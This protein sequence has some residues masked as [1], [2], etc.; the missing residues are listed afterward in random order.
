MVERGPE[1]ERNPRRVGSLEVIAGCMFSGKTDEVNMRLERERIALEIK[2]ERGEARKDIAQEKIRVFKP[3]IDNRYSNDSLDSHRGTSFPAILIEKET[4]EAIYEHITVNTDVVAIDE[5][6]FFEEN[7]IQICDKLADRGIRVIVAGLDRNF[8]GE[9][10]GSMGELLSQAEDSVKLKA[11]CMKCSKPA[12]RTQRFFIE[13]DSY[14][15]EIRR[16]ANYEDPEVVVGASEL[17]E[18][19]CRSCHEVPGKP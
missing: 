13:K 8:R 9:T 19:R 2:V 6:Q 17:Y 1:V 11:I 18:A 5:V 3:S 15:K 7:I 16:P 4:P 12:T 14:N 10:F